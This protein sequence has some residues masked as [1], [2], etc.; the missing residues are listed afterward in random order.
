V[1]RLIGVGNRWRGDDAVGLVV[2]ARVR[3]RLP[4]GIAVLEH[5]GE[6]IELIDAFEG[7]HA[8]WLIDAVCSGAQPGTVHRFDAAERALPAELFRVSTHRF[9]LADA[10]ELAGALGRLPPRVVVCGIEGSRFDPGGPLS[11]AVAAAAE[12]LADALSTELAAAFATVC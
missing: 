2:A 3:P 4:R 1:L 10:L 7:A 6:P 5:R 8:A 9:G 11:P 12:R